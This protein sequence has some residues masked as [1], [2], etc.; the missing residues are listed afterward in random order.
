MSRARQLIEAETPKK[1]LHAVRRQNANNF[2]E[3]DFETFFNA[4]VT[5]ALWSSHDDR[6]EGGDENLEGEELAPVTRQAMKAD[7]YDFLKNNYADVRIDLPAAGHDFWLTRCGHGAGFW[8][9]DWDD[10]AGRRLTDAAR[11]YGNVDLYVGDDGLVY[12]P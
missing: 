4:Y 7:C 9:G 12:Q 6:Y 2:S 11:V 3:P 5:C 10:A 8:D 1:A